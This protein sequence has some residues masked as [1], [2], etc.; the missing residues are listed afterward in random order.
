MAEQPAASS[1]HDW[2][3][4]VRP[5]TPR[6]G[7]EILG[8]ELRDAVDPPLFRAIFEAFLRHQVLLFNTGDLPP[9]R[10]VAF[11]RLH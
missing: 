1:E 2:P 7:A 10:Q 3:F 5:L 8:I 6:L 9:A 11:A 4:A